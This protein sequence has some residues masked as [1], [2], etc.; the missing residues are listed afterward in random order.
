M[1]RTTVLR[2]FA[3]GEAA[4]PDRGEAGSFHVERGHELMTHL[5]GARRGS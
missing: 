4:Q 3:S 5:T 2:I 1:Q